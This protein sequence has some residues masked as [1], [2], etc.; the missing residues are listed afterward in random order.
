MAATPRVIFDT[1]IFLRSVINRYSA[2]GR[3]VFD[4]SSDYELFTT[5]KIDAEV[6]EVLS[7]S[8]LR[9][10]F[11]Q[12]TDQTV[13]LIK[14]LLEQAHRVSINPD[15]VEPVCRDPKDDI[16]LAC[17]KVAQA[18]YL[19][20]EDNDLLVLQQYHN[21]KIVNVAAFLNVLEQRQASLAEDEGSHESQ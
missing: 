5:D 6:L 15:N 3:L 20:S 10:K 19:V 13:Q 12:I 17:A 7:R 4:Q 21:T 2:C 16:F 18:D 9:I 14:L 11:P 1:Q 8:S